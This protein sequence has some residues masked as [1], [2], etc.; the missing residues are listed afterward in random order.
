MQL[1]ADAANK[2]FSR[3]MVDSFIVRFAKEACQHILTV[4]DRHR[5][6]LVVLID[7]YSTYDPVLA[8]N[9]MNRVQ[10]HAG[11]ALVPVT[12]RNAA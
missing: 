7:F 6:I 5:Q 2:V 4:L 10:E 8:L 11:I 3:Q 1:H 12:A 9:T